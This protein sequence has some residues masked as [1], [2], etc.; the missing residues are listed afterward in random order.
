MSHGS[1]CMVVQ[2]ECF[3]KLLTLCYSVAL[4]ISMANAVISSLYQ[5]MLDDVSAVTV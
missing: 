5:T 3:T 4:A 1:N 2:T